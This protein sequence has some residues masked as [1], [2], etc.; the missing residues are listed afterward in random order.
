RPRMQRDAQRIIER[1]GESIDL[2]RPVGELPLAQR[3]MVAMA[4][5]LLHD[6]R[7][8]I[9]DEPTASLS[10]KE[11]QVL[12]RLV[13]QLRADD[14]SVLYVSHRLDEVFQISDRV[15]VLRDGERIDTVPT[16]ELTRDELIRRMIGRPIAT[17]TRRT[18]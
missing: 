5:A 16:V 9:M 3:Q 11:T 2:Q 8:L 17:F 15:T 18:P 6:C 1:L 10:A 4:R 14:V 7:L 12:L 13:Q